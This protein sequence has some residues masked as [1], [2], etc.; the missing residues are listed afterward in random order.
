MKQPELGQQIAD[1][2]KSKGLTQEELVDRC[3]VSVRTIQ[4]IETGEVTPRS[5]T[6]KTILAALDSNLD[7]FSSTSASMRYNLKPLKIGWIAG[8][9]YFVIGF[10]EG[11]MDIIR[12]L[13]EGTDDSGMVE[14]MSVFEMEF[15][16]PFYLIVKVIALVTF[17][18]FMK[19][20]ADFGNYSNHPP[21]KV[22]SI[23]LIA[24]MSLIITH[25]M[26]SLYIDGIDGWLIQIAMS[27]VL[28]ILYLIFGVLLF[29]L[30]KIYG[31][32]SI[33][34]GVS[35]AITG[36]LML[37][38]IPEAM[39]LMMLALIFQVLLLFRI[40]SQLHSQNPQN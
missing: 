15:N 36:L 38:V 28:G 40:Y 17:F 19:A 25:D 22:I 10:F 31:N 7:D 29:Q 13:N 4:R 1:L 32:L 30:K 14:G 12:A 6:L 39:L 18:L 35:T 33:A 21:L 26:L 23:A 5:F 34:A 8:V 3:N 37:L 27:V 20:F 2:R 16:V 11:P 9:I 24:S